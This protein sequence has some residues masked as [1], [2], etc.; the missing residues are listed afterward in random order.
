M[1]IGCISGDEVL[2]FGLVKDD[3]G[4]W[5]LSSAHSNASSELEL[6]SIDPTGKSAKVIIDRTFID[7]KTGIRWLVDYKNSRPSE[8]ESLQ[9]FLQREEE[10][11][12]AQLGKYKNALQAMGAE[13]IQCALY[14]TTI[15]NL[16][17]VEAP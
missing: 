1:T 3:Q 9:H 6:N 4:R 2:W 7:A 5:L 11:Y 13:P 10:T 15:G 17:L 12:T 14:F 8:G 16:H